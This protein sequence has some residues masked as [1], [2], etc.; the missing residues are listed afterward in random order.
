MVNFKSMKEWLP[1]DDAPQEF[2]IRG[3]IPPKEEE[4]LLKEKYEEEPIREIHV[5]ARQFLI[6]IPRLKCSQFSSFDFDF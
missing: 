3:N 4:G 2:W 6:N 1:K 5:M